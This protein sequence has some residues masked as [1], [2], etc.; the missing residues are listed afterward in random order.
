MLGWNMLW[1]SFNNK[2]C[3]CSLLGEATIRSPALH[4][5]GAIGKASGKKAPK[6]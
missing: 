3:Q 4:S 5:Q 2:I 6:V 1:A